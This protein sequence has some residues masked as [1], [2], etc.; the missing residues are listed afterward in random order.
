MIFYVAGPMSGYP[1]YNYPAF[2]ATAEKL[3][4]LGHVVHCPAESFGGD[5]TLAYHCYAR[6]D[7][8]L[9]LQTEAIC[10]LDRWAGSRGAC[11][12]V[13]VA[14]WLGLPCYRFAADDALTQFNAV[15][16]CEVYANGGV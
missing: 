4:A 11:T 14:L 8:H 1:D 7:L 5:Q 3:R 12:E 9:L 16:P 6:H 10:L 2:H 13:G 15:N